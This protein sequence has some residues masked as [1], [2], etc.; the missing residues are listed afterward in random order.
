MRVSLSCFFYGWM[1][2]MLSVASPLY[3]QQAPDGFRWVD[4]HSDKDQDTVAWVRR[5]LAGEKWTA[6]REI[7]VEFD[8]ALVV[9]TLRATPQLQPNSDTFAVWS[10]SLTNH[11]ITPLL[12]GANL[13]WLDWMRFADGAPM[14]P[15]VLYDSCAECVPDVYFTAFHYD[16]AQHVW[17]ARWLRGG[18]GVPLWNA[19]LANAGGWMQVYAGLAEPN[20]REMLGVWVHRDNAKP[21]EADDY[22]YRYDLDPAGGLERTQ[23]LTKKDAEAMKLRLCSAQGGLPG[24]T[25]GQD[26]ALCQPVAK[27]RYERKPVT[28]PPAN[29]RGQSAPPG[30]RH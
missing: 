7:G 4:F 28:T 8:A 9:T 6:I 24:L 1:V 20:G 15:A 30:G 19:S 10:V 22:V 29:N 13:R 27:S 14:E 16:Y 18:Q 26:A 23:L 21:K 25:R 17:A 5:S 2:A 3:A 12:R 11:A